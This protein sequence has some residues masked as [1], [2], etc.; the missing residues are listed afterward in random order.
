MKSA[1]VGLCALLAFATPAS[2]TILAEQAWYGD[3]GGITSDTGT[4]RSYEDFTAAASGKVTDIFWA[5]SVTNVPGLY[6]PLADGVADF[7]IEFY[8]AP[9]PYT[10]GSLISSQVVQG[11]AS[12][13][14]MFGVREFSAQ[15]GTT[16][17]LDAGLTYFLSIQGNDLDG[18]FDFAIPFTWASGNP[19]AGTPFMLSDFG[20]QGV[21]VGFRLEDNT[22]EVPEP[23]LLGL[24]GLGAMGLGL[25]RRRRKV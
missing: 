16:V 11:Y 17:M 20:L 10:L 6:E 18:G 25:A 23:A 8:A 7:T 9:D 15:L 5:G 3:G 2:A 12:A 14:N 4:M 1:L 21:G 19:T 13:M 24:F 22:P